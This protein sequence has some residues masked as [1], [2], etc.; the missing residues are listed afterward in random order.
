VKR[1]ASPDGSL[2]LKGVLK[3]QA[4][5]NTICYAPVSVPVTWTVALQAATPHDVKR[6]R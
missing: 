1:A 3:Y 5:D 4:C 6:P 2:T